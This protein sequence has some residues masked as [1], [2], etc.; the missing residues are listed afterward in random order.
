M[1][2]PKDKDEIIKERLKKARISFCEFTNKSAD[3]F[4]KS[5]E[6]YDEEE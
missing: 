2:T 5:K 3:M 1:E 6:K 4:G